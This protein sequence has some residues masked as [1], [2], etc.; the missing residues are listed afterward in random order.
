MQDAAIRRQEQQITLIER[1]WKESVE[2]AARRARARAEAAATSR[3]AASRASRAW[4]A[5]A[6]ARRSSS[7]MTRAAR[8]QA[9]SA[10]DHARDMLARTRAAGGRDH[11]RAPSARRAARRARAR[12]RA[13]ST[14]SRSPRAKYA[15]HA[16]PVATVVQT[17]FIWPGELAQPG[18]ALVA[19]LDPTDKY[20]QV[21]V[22]V[23][24]VD[25]VRVGQRVEI[26]LDSRARPPRPR[27]GQLP[28]RSSD[29]HAGEDRDALGPPRPGLPR[30]GADPRRGRALPAR[31]RGQR[32]SPRRGAR[33]PRPIA[34]AA[35][36]EAMAADPRDPPSRLSRCATAPSA[37]SPASTS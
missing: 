34:D 17:Q 36:R 4:C 6:P 24:D 5:P 9:A 14:S 3:R 10:R 25:R 22:P 2:R 8:D 28:R 29:V 11:G 27:R 1:T 33:A 21:Y 7:T 32:L 12:D 16:P 35:R 19:V 37:R 18:S 30:Q 20:V 26:E 31:H 13:S 15:I 23:A